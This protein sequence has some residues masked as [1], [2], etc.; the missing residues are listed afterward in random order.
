MKL[1][2]KERSRKGQRARKGKT[3]F[4]LFEMLMFVYAMPVMTVSQ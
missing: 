4:R 1:D 3:V 2:R